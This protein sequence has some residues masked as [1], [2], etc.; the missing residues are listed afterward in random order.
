MAWIMW[1]SGENEAHPRQDVN[2]DDEAKLRGIG[3]ALL[4][5]HTELD[6]A[7]PLFEPRVGSMRP[8][9]GIRYPDPDGPIRIQITKMFAPLT[10]FVATFGGPAINGRVREAIEAIEP[11]VHRYL[12]VEFTLPEGTTGGALLAPQYRDADR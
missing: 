2:A 7:D 3:G 4:A 12:P 1:G 10:D 9:V 8:E 6:P 11:G 5:R